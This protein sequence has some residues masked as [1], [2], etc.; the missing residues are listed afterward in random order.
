MTPPPIAIPNSTKKHPKG[1]HIYKR[2]PGQCENP[3]VRALRPRY[4]KSTKSS[5]YQNNLRI[6]K[7][8]TLYDF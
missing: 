4:S 1:R 6:F 2:I 7:A 5:V 8:D 3:L